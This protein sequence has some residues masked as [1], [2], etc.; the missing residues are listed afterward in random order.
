MTTR[1]PATD[2]HTPRRHGVIDIGTNAVK[3]V[4]GSVVKGRVVLHHFGRRPTRLGTS[5]DSSKHIRADAAQ[6]TAAAVEEL[7][8]EARAHGAMEVIAGGTYALR[9][10]ENGKA[11][12]ELIRR[13][14]GVPVRILSSSQEGKLAMAAVR[15]R[16]SATPAPGLTVIDIGGG[17][18]QL[19]VARGRHPVRA[20]SVPLG[21]VVLTERYLRRDPIQP[22]EYAR[23]KSH[24]EDVVSD[25]FEKRPLLHTARQDFVV[26]G[27]AA[28]TALRMLG[29][30]PGRGLPSIS[31]AALKRLE[32]RC[33]AATIEER[34]Q[35][36][37]MTPDR[38]DIMP[39]GLAVLIAFAHHASRHAVRVFEGGWREG[40]ILERAR[41]SRARTRPTA[42]AT[43]A[44]RKGR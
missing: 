26:A 13:Q 37:G 18:A 30:R 8:D 12:A 39:A 38:A 28:T 6:R 20:R 25:L 4:V 19:T 11:V 22:G 29:V 36:A 7:A 14:S 40:L 32:Q 27:G 10:A 35:F 1:P 31:L 15:A 33:L 17:S 5:L 9:S 44:A 42:R 16:M 41:R 3:L 34:R 24:V 2:R 21:A 43:A 23:L